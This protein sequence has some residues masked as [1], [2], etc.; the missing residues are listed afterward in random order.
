[1]L[2]RRTF[3]QSSL[4]SS[5][6][7]TAPALI[8]AKDKKFRTALIGSGW[9]GTN[10]LREA[11][12]SKEC[13]IVALCDVDDNQLEACLKMVKDESGANPKRYKDH[14]E[15]LEKEQPDIRVVAQ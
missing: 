1:M 6:A 8:S 12:A 5:L 13:E 2:S 4:A 9:W 7:L 14:R 3:V 11:I 10:I 15:L